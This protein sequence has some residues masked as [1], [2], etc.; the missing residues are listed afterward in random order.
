M[1]RHLVRC[2]IRARLGLPF[3]ETEKFT[4]PSDSGI[5]IIPV[6]VASCHNKNGDRRPSSRAFRYDLRVTRE[7]NIYEHQGSPVIGR[8]TSLR[9]ELSDKVYRPSWQLRLAGEMTTQEGRIDVN[10]RRRI[11]RRF[12][13]APRKDLVTIDVTEYLEL[14]ERHSLFE[15]ALDPRAARFPGRSAFRLGAAAAVFIEIP[16]E[17]DI[18]DG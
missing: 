10:L 4:D 17:R 8:Q 7:L 16:E 12:R 13:R 18:R 2:N 11:N 3:C 6:A 14:I 9:L 5:E 15:L 1:R